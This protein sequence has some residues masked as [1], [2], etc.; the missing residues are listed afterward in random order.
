MAYE[1]GP[2][3]CPD[4]Q[5]MYVPQCDVIAPKDL[6]YHYSNQLW[7]AF[8]QPIPRFS[9][10]TYAV[11][12]HQQSS[13]KDEDYREML[14]QRRHIG[15]FAPPSGQITRDICRMATLLSTGFLPNLHMLQLTDVIFEKKSFLHLMSVIPNLAHLKLSVCANFDVST[16]WNG[17]K[18]RCDTLQTIRIECY[19]AQ[20]NQNVWSVFANVVFSTGPESRILWERNVMTWI[21]YPHFP[22]PWI[23]IV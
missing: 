15:V 6:A 22:N 16:V 14:K 3:L 10:S 21:R 12:L 2:M 1:G 7:P 19:G 5:I 17:L 13:S 8:S 20:N 4:L 23:G 11:M 18:I 9:R